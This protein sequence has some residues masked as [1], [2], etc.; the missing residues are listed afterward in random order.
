MA[1]PMVIQAGWRHLLGLKLHRDHTGR[2]S[3]QEGHPGL[4]AGLTPRQDTLL[5][6]S[7]A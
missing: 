3:Y 5:Q 6:T 1:E 7:Q 4:G 2:H